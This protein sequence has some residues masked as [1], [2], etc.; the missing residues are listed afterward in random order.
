[1]PPPPQLLLPRKKVKQGEHCDIVERVFKH[2][3][4]KESRGHAKK[5]G[6]VGHLVVCSL[7][8]VCVGT[9]FSLGHL[10]R[11]LP[12]TS[13]VPSLFLL[14]LKSSKSDFINW[15]SRS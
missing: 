1:M 13:M 2:G 11:R 7:C 5:Y 12:Y 15:M 3:D 10:L 6:E 8:I 14:F 4:I 9:F